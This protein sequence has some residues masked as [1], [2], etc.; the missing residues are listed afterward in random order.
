MHNV[1]Q[2]NQPAVVIPLLNSS[3]ARV[4]VDDLVA[5]STQRQ[6][7]FLRH[8]EQFGRSRFGDRAAYCMSECEL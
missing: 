3:L 2:L 8:I 5:E 1:E 7:W 4:R 6:V